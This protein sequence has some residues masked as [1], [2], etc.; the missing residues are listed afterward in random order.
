M[1]SKLMHNRLLRRLP[2]VMDSGFEFAISSMA[3]VD[4]RITAQR[5]GRVW[6]EAS[7]WPARL[8]VTNGEGFP[9]VLSSMVIEPGQMVK[10]VGRK[11][12]TLLVMP[13]KDPLTSV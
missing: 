4:T 5:A 8:S 7:C 13:M 6:Y 10:V 9:L 2:A 3:E 12:I 11:G 1:R